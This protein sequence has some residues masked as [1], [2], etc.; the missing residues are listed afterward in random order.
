MERFISRPFPGTGAGRCVHHDAFIP[1]KYSSI[2]GLCSEIKKGVRVW[3]CVTVFLINRRFQKAAIRVKRY[4]RQQNLQSPR[5]IGAT[6]VFG[7][8]NIM[9]PPRLRVP[10]RKY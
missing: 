2:A 10:P 7:Y 5:K 4:S 6:P 1:E 9:T 3:Y 8:L